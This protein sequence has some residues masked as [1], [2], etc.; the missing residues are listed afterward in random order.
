MR[1]KIEITK[2]MFVRMALFM[3][4]IGAAILA[5][6]YFENNPAEFENI[7]ANS[8]EST[9]N[10]NTVN[11]INQTGSITVNTFVLKLSGK[12][13]HIQSHNKFLRKYHNIRNN[14]V[15]K[16]EVKT[17]TTPLILS[18]HYLVFQ[19]FFFTLPDEEPLIS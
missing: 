1:F 9:N 12:K 19:N 17:Q 7:Q 3:V 8:E 11:L 15:L 10:S 16:A 14:Q 13:L 4:I 18:Y 2:K 6:V 5:D